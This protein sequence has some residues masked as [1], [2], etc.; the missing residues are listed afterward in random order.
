M[1]TVKTTKS[2]RNNSISQQTCGSSG[3][4]LLMPVISGGDR[5]KFKTVWLTSVRCGGKFN[6]DEI[7]DFLMHPNNTSKN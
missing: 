4:S 2:N 3:P 1:L 6:P 5:H 7:G